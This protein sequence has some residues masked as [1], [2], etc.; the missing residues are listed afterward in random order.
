M[1]IGLIVFA[2]KGTRM[3]SPIPKQFIEA[4]GKELVVY[5]IE[6]FQHSSLIDE[7]IL[8]THKDYLNHV[9]E[10]KE[11]YNL[12][13]VKY[14]IPGGETRQESVK[15]GLLNSSYSDNDIVLIH[16]GDRPLVSEEIISRNIKAINNC[17]G[18]CTM[19]KHSESLSNVSNLGRCKVV[20]GIDIDVQTPQTFRY[21]LIKTAHV[22]RENES[23]SDDIG[24]IEDEYKVSYVE[25]D[26]RNFKVTTD[27][28]LI[29][30]KS[31]ILE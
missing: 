8:V 6:V 3:N 27:I 21:G 30:F 5:T 11:K 31:M 14:I 4:D 29:A 10:L 28:D 1:N 12:T 22:K 25:G 18:V 2:G 24:L 13:K 17:D 26:K 7:I 9:K 23:F 19:I 16:D 20:N 15:L